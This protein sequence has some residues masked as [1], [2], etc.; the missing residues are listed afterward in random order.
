MIRRMALLCIGCTVWAQT[1]P[2]FQIASIKPNHSGTESDSGIRLGD[3]R[4]IAVN[5]TLKRCIAGAY[6]IAPDR[7]F[8]GPAW[9]DVDRFD[10]V[11]VT[12]QP[13]RDEKI[14]MAMLKSLLAERFKLAIHRETRMLSAYLMEADD[15]GPKLNEPAVGIS[16]I[17]LGRGNVISVNATLD[18]L[19][20]VLSQQ[21][22][23]PV[24]NR[25][26][27][28]GLFHI[29]LKWSS[30]PSWDHGTPLFT[31]MEEQLGLRLRAEKVPT[32]V[33][34]IG[35]AERPTAN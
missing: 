20:D 2:R 7:I 11:A 9:L 25:T 30:D 31:A 13:V 23:A 24:L 16:I 8:S 19:A 17:N 26:G 29:R 35:H 6:A 1:A 32:E 34:V 22:D 4:L 10:I 28:K 15:G 33:L 27:L 12:D 18:Q 14:L 21:T 3:E 5:V